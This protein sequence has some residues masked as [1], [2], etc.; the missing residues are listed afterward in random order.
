MEQNLVLSSRCYEAAGKLIKEAVVSVGESGTGSPKKGKKY[1]DGGDG[2]EGLSNLIIDSVMVAKR[3][4]N[5]K[6][7]L[8]LYYMNVALAIAGKEESKY[9]WGGIGTLRCL[10][11]PL[12][13]RT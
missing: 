7:E 8:G 10:S 13:S 11:G 3:Q 12:D 9:C 1:V 4:G 6:N 2:G 5:V